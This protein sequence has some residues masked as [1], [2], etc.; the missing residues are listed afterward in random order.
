[1]FTMQRDA[2]HID[3]S[4]LELRHL[5][6]FVAVAEEL[7]FGRAARRLGIAQPPLSQQIRQLEQ[8]IGA[9]LFA[10]TSRQVALTPAGEALLRG[11]RRVLAEMRLAAAAARRAEAGETDA[12]RVAYTDS[13]ALSVLPSAIQGFRSAMP[14]VHLDLVEGST[15]AQVDAVVRDLVDLAVVRGPVVQ[16][17]LRTEVVLREPFLLALPE[18]HPLC[19]RQTVELAVLGAESMVLFPRHLA[20]DFHDTISA[21]CRAAGFTPLVAYEGA[22]YQTILSLV[23]AGL[24]VS[25]VPRSVANLQ[26]SGVVYRVITD[27]P[28]RAEIA[29]VYRAENWSRPLETM[30]WALRT[31]GGSLPVQVD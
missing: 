24:G 23:A 22:E 15:A 14:T 29:A 9:S 10:R 5:R 13:A 26:R 2:P 21:M 25:L 28:P 4:S 16:P 6:Y 3:L 11:A 8:R 30:L 31:A 17:A 20:P 7:H 19:E 1:L 18:S 12:L 27:A